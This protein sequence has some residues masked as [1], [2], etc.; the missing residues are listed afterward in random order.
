[1]SGNGAESCGHL[2]LAVEVELRLTA[3]VPPC[4]RD[5]VPLIIGPAQERC[6]YYN[7]QGPSSDLIFNT[8]FT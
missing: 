6:N 5:V 3:V 2:R 7:F 8:Y 1:M 4:H